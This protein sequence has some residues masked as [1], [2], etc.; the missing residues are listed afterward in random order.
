VVISRFE[1]PQ[2]IAT[3]ME[4]TFTSEAQ[5]DDNGA[6]DERTIHPSDIDYDVIGIHGDRINRKTNKKQYLVQWDGFKRKS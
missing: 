2:K 3:I 5:E 4:R 6:E 1:N